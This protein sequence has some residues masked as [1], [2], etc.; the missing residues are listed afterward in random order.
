MMPTKKTGKPALTGLKPLPRAKGFDP[1]LL[2][3]AKGPQGQKLVPKR[4]LVPGKG[5]HR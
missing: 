3:G 2:R 1:G 4:G 5:G